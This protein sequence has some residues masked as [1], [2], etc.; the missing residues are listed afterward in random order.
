MIVVKC[1]SWGIRSSP[2]A[3]GFMGSVSGLFWGVQESGTESDISSV[4][5]ETEETL[6]TKHGR[7]VRAVLGTKVLK[8]LHVAATVVPPQL[9]MT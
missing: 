2:V 9:V 7:H 3:K 4:K 1:L 8:V 5:C 6:F